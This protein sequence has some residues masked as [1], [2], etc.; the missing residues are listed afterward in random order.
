MKVRRVKQ[1]SDDYS[2]AI[3]SAI[4]KGLNADLTYSIY[5]SLSRSAFNKLTLL[6]AGKSVAILYLYQ[7]MAVM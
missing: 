6:I 2:M 3:P 4:L 5:P 1:D 7:A